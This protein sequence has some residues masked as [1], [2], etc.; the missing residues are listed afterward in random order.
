[1]IYEKLFF[2]CRESLVSLTIFEHLIW[3][4]FFFF[5]IFLQYPRAYP[6]SL[7]YMLLAMRNWPID[8]ILKIFLL[9]VC[10]SLQHCPH[11]L[12]R[13]RI[14]EFF[15]VR[16]LTSFLSYFGESLPNP[17]YFLRFERTLTKFLKCIAQPNINKISAYSW[18]D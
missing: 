13:L 10:L 7:E 2:F 14:I 18:K 6:Y 15:F 8:Y 11:S 17:I 9:S 5:R 16:H 4:Q 3:S 1:M 12:T